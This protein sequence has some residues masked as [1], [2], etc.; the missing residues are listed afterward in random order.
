MLVYCGCPTPPIRLQFAGATFLTSTLRNRITF[1]VRC[2]SRHN[3][4]LLKPTQPLLRRHSYDNESERTDGNSY[5]QRSTI[6]RMSFSNVGFRSNFSAENFWEVELFFF[7][8]CFISWFLLT[9]FISTIFQKYLQI[10]F[11]FLYEF[12]CSREIFTLSCLWALLNLKLLGC[13]SQSY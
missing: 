2:Q 4:K 7:R 13:M 8:D 6:V 11:G 10:E 12:N 1:R 5:W 3:L 9:R